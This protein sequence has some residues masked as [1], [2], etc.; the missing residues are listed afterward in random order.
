MG[1]GM[2]TVD[3]S[4]RA[5]GRCG[6]ANMLLALLSLIIR[7]R[8]TMVMWLE[9]RWTIVRLRV[10]NR[11]ETPSPVRR[12]LSRPTTFVRT[13][14]LRDVTG[15]LS[16]SIPGLA[17]RVWVTETCRCRLLENRVGK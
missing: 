2:G 15:L 1:L 16:S 9:T 8:H 5:H 17:V 11:H 14:M 13:D 7:L 6:R 10:M 4:V 12:L 3:S